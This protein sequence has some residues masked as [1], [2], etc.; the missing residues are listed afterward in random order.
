MMNTIRM[1]A[2]AFPVMLLMACGGGG[3]GSAA[4][5][6]TNMPGTG[7]PTNMP[8]MPDPVTL[9]SYAVNAEMARMRVSGATE[10]T[11]MN[12]TT[13]MGIV[14]EI[15]RIANAAN[16]FEFSNFGPTANAVSVTCMNNSSCSGT[17]PDAGTLTFSLTGIE[18]L[19]LVDDTGFENFDSDTQA[20]MVDRSVT[21]IQ[22]QAAARQSDGTQLTFQTYGGWLTNSVFGVEL[23][24][25]TQDGVTTDRFAS[26]SFGM[27]SGNR[28]TEPQGGNSPFRWNGSMVGVNASKEIIQGE[29][30]IFTDLLQQNTEIDLLTFDKIVNISDGST[31]NKIEWRS[32]PIA[33]DG[34]FSS[35]S[36]TTGDIS[37]TFFGTGHTEIGGTFNRDGIIGAFGGTRQ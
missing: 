2:V 4:S 20:V 32:I 6:T 22:S 34:T 11:A 13:E 21:V 10:P 27:A 18:D 23:L 37:G 9:P 16:T 5:P 35:T 30:A 14:G 28:P 26:F 36:Q 15:Q 1:I 19:S 29:L 33:T 12:T 3:G 25:V 24:G 17:V 8:D 7:G 31:L